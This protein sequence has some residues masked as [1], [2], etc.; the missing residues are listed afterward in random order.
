VEVREMDAPSRLADV[1]AIAGLVQGL[2]RHAA[3][4]PAEP[5][6]SE[7]IAWSAFRAARDGV[8]AEILHDGRLI[9]LA[10]AARAATA[11]ASHHAREADAQDA[12]NGIERILR[13]RGAPARH[14][15]AHERGGMEGLLE[16][17]VRE[18][19]AGVRLS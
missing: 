4:R 14:R 8:G 2:A 12:L 9:P 15:T 5:V 1:A 17:L 11:L 16:L 6:A 3:E 7:A 19:A 18:T 13:D 10:E